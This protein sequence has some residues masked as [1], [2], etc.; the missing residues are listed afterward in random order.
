MLFKLITIIAAIAISASAQEPDQTTQQPE[1][2]LR[3]SVVE[4]TPSQ[5]AEAQAPFNCQA[6]ADLYSKCGIDCLMPDLTWENIYKC[7]FVCK[8]HLCNGVIGQVSTRTLSSLA[9]LKFA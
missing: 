7:Q 6:C 8:E 4:I 3:P 5:S 1:S 9:I 2:T